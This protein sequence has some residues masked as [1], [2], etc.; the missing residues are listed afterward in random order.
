MYPSITHI[1]EATTSAQRFPLLKYTTNKTIGM[2]ILTSSHG[3]ACK[4]PFSELAVTKNTNK[5]L[6]IDA[7]EKAHFS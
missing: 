3:T 5:P 1:T 4:N 2:M 7:V 6:A